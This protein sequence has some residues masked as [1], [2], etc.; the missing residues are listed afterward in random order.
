MLLMYDVSM[1]IEFQVGRRLSDKHV[2]VLSIMSQIEG[3]W[4]SFCNH[5]LRSLTCLFQT[6]KT[7]V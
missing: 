5:G 6:I 2:M 1:M 3:I 7:Y 4:S